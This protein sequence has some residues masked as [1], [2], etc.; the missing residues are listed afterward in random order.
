LNNDFFC[1][2][3]NDIRKNVDTIFSKNISFDEYQ[4]NVK[5][6]KSNLSPLLE[7]KSKL[8][9]SITLHYHKI[10][11]KYPSLYSLRFSFSLNDRTSHYAEKLS[12]EMIRKEYSRI[13]DYLNKFLNFSRQR[14][15]LK[16]IVGYFWVIMRDYAGLPYIH[17]GFYLSDGLFN[18]RLAIEIKQLW[19]QVTDGYGCSLIF[20]VSESYGNSE[21]YNNNA[22]NFLSPKSL[23]NRN[24]KKHEIRHDFNKIG[25]STLKYFCS[26][27]NVKEYE[28]YL[29]CIAR[30]SYPVYTLNSITKWKGRIGLIDELHSGDRNL[31]K[32]KTDRELS[33]FRGYSVSQIKKL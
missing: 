9:D 26:A 11:S 3:L 32:K 13:V 18:A 20:D 31:P 2:L 33:K 6:V 17:I 16:K 29:T 19:E 5:V 21:V 1:D 27:E 28:R 7:N 23:V 10:R 15:F 8:L 24:N 22:I 12:A 30:E 14:V 25:D 4:N